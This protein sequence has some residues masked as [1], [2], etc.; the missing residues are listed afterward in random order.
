MPLPVTAVAAALLTALYLV[1][2]IRVIGQRRARGIA[3]G[4]GHPALERAY[5]AQANFAEYV[6]LEHAAFTC[7][8]AA[9]SSLCWIA[10]FSAFGDSASTHRALGLILLGLLEGLRAPVPLVFGLA[11]ALVLGRALHAFGIS[12]EPEE[13][14]FRVAGM[15]LTFAMLAATGLLLAGFALAG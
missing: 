12:R 14:R 11:A 4:T 15:V 9:R 3:L 7:V 10:R 6:P 5:R 13:L 1:L 8:H 2:C